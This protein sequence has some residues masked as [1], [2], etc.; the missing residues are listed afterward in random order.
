MILRG[1]YTEEISGR[2]NMTFSC[3]QNR[4]SNRFEIDIGQFSYR[5][6]CKGHLRGHILSSNLKALR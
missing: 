5:I 4:N 6:L 3:K 1:N 2:P